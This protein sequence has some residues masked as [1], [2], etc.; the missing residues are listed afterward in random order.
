MKLNNIAL[1]FKRINNSKIS[2]VVACLIICVILFATLMYYIFNLSVGY[3]SG[4][5]L[6]KQ[7]FKIDVDVLNFQTQNDIYYIYRKSFQGYYLE[8]Y[9]K[10]C[11]TDIKKLLEDK[12]LH[13]RREPSV[14]IRPSENLPDE[15]IKQVGLFAKSS[16]YHLYRLGDM[17]SPIDSIIIII[18]HNHR[19]LFE[20][21]LDEKTGGFIIQIQK[22]PR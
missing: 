15:V 3:T 19:Y 20:M 1:C 13:I 10:I 18:C 5:N 6:L 14:Y 7:K 21:T 16:E 2:L 4:L 17:S 22:P 12:S 11:L 8:I 9:G